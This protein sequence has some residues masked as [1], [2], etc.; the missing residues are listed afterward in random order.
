MLLHGDPWIPAGSSATADV[1]NSDAKTGVLQLVPQR[2]DKITALLTAMDRRRR[3][4]DKVFPFDTTAPRLAFML[5]LSKIGRE[6]LGFVP[7]SLRHGGATHDYMPGLSMEDIQAMWR[8]F[9]STSCRRYVQAGRGL[10]LATV[11]PTSVLRNM[12]KALWRLITGH[13]LCVILSSHTP[14]VVHAGYELAKS[15]N[16]WQPCSPY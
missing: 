13:V 6:N 10:I 14:R 3:S 15:S 11:L 2:N 5:A 9:S 8:Q 4:S 1:L 12:P 16:D 7:H